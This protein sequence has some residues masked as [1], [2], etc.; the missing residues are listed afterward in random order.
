ML[1]I[2]V[3]EILRTFAVISHLAVVALAPAVGVVVLHAAKNVSVRN[4]VTPVLAG[5]VEG[6]RGREPM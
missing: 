2:Y 3:I 1:Q 5:H 4:L 6:L